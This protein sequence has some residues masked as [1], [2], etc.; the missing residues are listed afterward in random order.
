MMKRILLSFMLLAGLLT[1][2][3]A[4]KSLPYEYG[5]E[6]DLTAEGWT[7]TN[8]HSKSV[9]DTKAKKT[10]SYGFLFYYNSNPP[11]YLISPELSVPNSATG[12]NVSFYYKNY[13]SSYAETFQVGYSTTTNDVENFTFGDVITASD[14]QWTLYQNSFPTDVKYVCIKYTSNDQYYL[15]IDDINI[16]CTI[17]GPA[18]SVYDGDANISTGYDYNFGLA[19]AGTQKSFTLKNSGT[20]SQT[21]S[22][23]S[24]TGGYTAE[25]SDGG[26]LAAEGEIT[27]T[28][29]M[30]DTTGD[31]VVTIQSSADGINDFVINVSGTVRDA[32]KMW[33][34]FSDG[35]PTGWTNSGNWTINNSGADGTTSGGGYA[36]NTSYG[37]NKLMYTPLVTIAEGEKLYLQIKGHG[38]TATWNKLTIQYSADG[39]NWQNAKVLES[40]TNVWQSLEV[41]EIPAGNWYIGFYGSYVYFTDIYG[42]QESTAPVLNLSQGS[43]NF[44]LISENTTS[45]PFTITNSGKSAL[46]GLKATSDN[47]NFTVAITDNATTI[48]ANGGTA[49]FTVTMKS[50]TPGAQSATIT[51]SS[52]N[53]DNLVFAV[54]GAVAKEGTT[55]VDFNDNELPARWEKSG[56]TSF[57]DGCAYFYYSYNN[58]LNSPKVKFED[59]DFLVIKAKMASS[60]GYVTVNGSAD[61]GATW[62]AYTKKLDSSLLNQSD[63]TTILLSDIPTTVNKLQFNGYYCYVDEIAGLNYAAELSVTKGGE[64]VNTPAG[65]NFGECSEEASVTYSFANTGAGTLNITNVEI[66]NSEDSHYT[67]NWTEAV[68]APF[69]LI[70]TQ[71]Y[72]SATPGEKHAT[73]TVTTTEGQFVINVQGTTMAA[74]A[75]KMAIYVGEELQEAGAMM[76][77]G[78]ITANATKEFSIKNDGTGTLNITSIELPEGY[79]IDITAPTQEAPLALTAGTSQTVKLTLAADAKAIRMDKVVIWPAG[80]LPDFTLGVSATVLPNAEIVDFNDNKTPQN[81]TSGWSYDD[82]KAYVTQAKEM[83]TSKLQFTDG[84]FFIIKATSYDNYD[85]NYLEIYGS[86][87]NGATWTAFETKRFISRSQIPYASYA[88]LVVDEIPANVNRIKIKGYYVRIDEIVGLTTDP[89]DPTLA[90]FSDAEATKSVASGT[91]AN[92]GWTTNDASVTLYL[93][94][95]GTGSLTIN[96]ISSTEAFT[97]ATANNATTISADAETPLALTISMVATDNEGYHHD[98]IT[99]AT[100]GGNFVIPVTGVVMNEEK[101]Y[102]NFATENA[103]LPAGWTAN[104]WTITANA[105]GYIASGSSSNDLVS[106]KL[107]VSEGEKLIISASG[108]V[109]S[110]YNKTILTYSYSEDGTTWSEAQDIAS[111]LKSTSTWYTIEITDVPTTAQYIKFTGKYAYIQRIYGFK[112]VLEPLMTSDIADYDFGMQTEA[113]QKT[114][115][116][117]NEGLA[118][119]KGLKAEL[120]GD[121]AADYEV[122]LTGTTGEGNDELEPNAQATITITQKFNLENLGSHSATL[123]VSAE[124]QDSVF[125]NLSGKTRDASKLYVDFEEYQLP[126]TWTSGWTISSQGGNH[127]ASAGVA[128]EKNIRTT[129]LLV[130]EG[131]KL[132]FDAARQYSS[133]VPTLRVRY[134][135]DGSVTWTEKDLSAQITSNQFTSLEVTDIPAGT[136]VLEFVG[137]R[138]LIDNL[139]GFMPTTAPLI[140]LTK[141]DVSVANGSTYD[142]GTLTS[143]DATVTYVVKNTGNATLKSTFTASGDVSISPATAVLEAGETQ[144]ITV[145]L[146]YGAPFTDKSGIVTITSENGV[147]T[148]TLNFTGKTFDETAFFADFTAEGTPE[149]WYNNGWTFANGEA[150]TSTAENVFITEKLEIKEANEVLTYEAK[151][152]SAFTKKLVVS[153]STDRKNWTDTDITEELTNEY[154]TFEVKG[155][156]VGTY[157]LKFVGTFAS[158]DDLKGWHKTDVPEHDIFLANVNIPTADLVPAESISATIDVA[159]LRA[160]ETFT[161]TLYFGDN[162][163]AETTTD[164]AVGKG[165]IQTL[166]L[167][168]AAPETETT[169][170][171]YIKVTTESGLTDESEKY[172]V[173]V[174]HI[175]DLSVTAFTRKL[176]EGES[177]AVTAND[178]NKFTASFDI[179]VKNTGSAAENVT[180]KVWLNDTEVGSITFTDA[181]TAGESTTL[182]VVA[183]DIPAGEGGDFVFK[184]AAYLGEKAFTTETAVTINV[185]AAAPKF[186]LYEGE[187]AV[188]RDATIDFGTTRTTVTKTFILKNE[189]NATLQFIGASCS[190]DFESNILDMAKTIAVGESTS[191]VVSL[192][193]QEGQ[194]G[195]KQGQLEF[196]YMVNEE[197]ISFTVNLTG[198]T[199]AEDTW[200]ETFDNDNMPAGWLNDGSWRVSYDNYIYSYDE[201]STLTTPR[202]TATEGEVLTFEIVKNDDANTL[203]VEISSDRQNWT[204]INIAS[205]VGEQDITAPAAGDFYVRFTGKYIYLDN[206]V[207][208]KQSM[209]E[210]DIMIASARIPAEATV[211]NKT[212][213]SVTVKELLGKAEQAVATFYV[214]GEAVATSDTIAISAS[215]MQF[216]TLSFTPYTATEGAVKAYVELS[217]PETDYTVK[218]AEQDFT[219][220][221][222]SG[223]YET[224]AGKV[225]DGSNQP[226]EGASVTATATTAGG[227]VVIYSTTT[228]ADGQFSLN[229]YQSALN[230]TLKVEN[231]DDSTEKNIGTVPYDGE[232]IIV[233]G[234]VDAIRILMIEKGLTGTVYTLDGVRVAK[235]KKGQ[236]YIVNG[237]KTSIK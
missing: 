151:R 160:D 13:S 197:P 205:L 73:I 152:N 61:N 123:A 179:T 204:A 163:I 198:R 66:E 232:L 32:N 67:T 126:E 52:D 200:M 150:K 218:T 143:E 57:S 192:N 101:M 22:V 191:V 216:F 71:P 176:A 161:A 78:I 17:S 12:V 4:Q 146:P 158:V 47:E 226:I 104:N 178:N 14:A 50:V 119:L 85:D 109:T 201:T 134:S 122:A 230:Y 10:G 211:N 58:M 72:N 27:L 125:A 154:Q 74:D 6:T 53:A 208:W 130:T 65:Y 144:E 88:T 2:L 39:M 90:V 165:N 95:A 45:E 64:A 40:I 7:R 9:K 118:T 184:A 214:D 173:K 169:Y 182:T 37:S 162:K 177:E 92:L 233:L 135:T 190:A 209:V 175:H 223:A 138:V 103:T 76:D 237:K 86:A 128:V 120:K 229:I 193:P 29:G 36:A 116:V 20:E 235:P 215:G 206:F 55:T 8:C 42:G 19:T 43:F 69:D 148:L 155:L 97:V 181:L 174:A 220:N 129:P 41:T 219:I 91:V 142:F 121:G 96:S 202:L 172:S 25:V 153:Y 81:W 70:I 217:V 15:Y 68:A 84:D 54:S 5:F 46:T 16:S 124:S 139:Y 145:T 31:G 221:A 94:N 234:E 127:Y 137:Q 26:V 199:I 33:C 170:E 231:D 82:G 112:G 196:T 105:N 51:I 225:V 80:G 62:T 49:T 35:L 157:Y 114:F 224:L 147:G 195:K 21:I 236:I 63:F 171:A 56:N 77:F 110:Y 131:E 203:N 79:S 168:G 159:A 108:D 133:D 136:V 48:A 141:D 222:E 111:T 106:V 100:D 227:V 1:T 11:Q 44:G 207:G 113:T 189:G 186:A 89:N 115:I 164:P 34:N 28:I 194:Y 30:A 102:V 38:S 210:H 212:D 59:G 75:P 107:N 99:V 167:T 3:Q 213:I 18:L 117:K 166:T 180:A 183:Q 83:T 156:E 98:T 228:D 188:E 149:G 24:V 187:T 60:Y 93:K 185:T 132:T 87:D 140:A 23:K